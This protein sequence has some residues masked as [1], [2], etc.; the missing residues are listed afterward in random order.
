M[1]AAGLVALEDGP[2]RL[3]EDHARARRL[4]QGI[5][6]IVPGAVD[7]EQVETNMVYVDTSVVGLG[8]VEALE[9]LASLG[10]GA[11]HSA[12]KVRLVTHL[13]VDDAGVGVALDAWRSIAAGSPE[14]A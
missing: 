5:A 10:V 6:E 9:R 14:E 13:D 11:T 2:A 12:G 7:L 3:H 8:E 4:A 1:A